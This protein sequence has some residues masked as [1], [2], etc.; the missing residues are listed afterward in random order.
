M[1]TTLLVFAQEIATSR[2]EKNE[3]LLARPVGVHILFDVRMV[4]PNNT[5]PLR[6]F[7]L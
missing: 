2:E 3:I 1:K 7:G 4:K 6:Q 5:P